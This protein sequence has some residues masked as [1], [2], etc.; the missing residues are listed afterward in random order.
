M[1][2][3]ASLSCTLP[4]LSFSSLSLSLSLSF[5][6]FFKT[7]CR[8]DEITVAFSGRGS[9]V[10]VRDRRRTA[11]RPRKRDGPCDIHPYHVQ[12]RFVRVLPPPIAPR[13]RHCVRLTHPFVPN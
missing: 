12:V 9:I 3:L 2:D 1:P 8:R 6:F 7:E 5:F 13:L 4:P 10:Y 11:I